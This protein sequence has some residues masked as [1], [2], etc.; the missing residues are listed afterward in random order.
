MVPWDESRQ[1]I[2]EFWRLGYTK[3]EAAD[4][5]DEN[6]IPPLGRSAALVAE[7]F[8]TGHTGATPSPR[9]SRV[10][11]D[12]AWR[13][14]SASHT[15]NNGLRLMMVWFD[16]LLI[17][18]QSLLDGKLVSL[19]A[20][21]I[22]TPLLQ[23]TREVPSAPYEKRR[24]T[25]RCLVSEVPGYVRT[26]RYCPL[27]ATI[28]TDTFPCRAWWPSSIRS[29]SATATWLCPLCGN[30][31]RRSLSIDAVRTRMRQSR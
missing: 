24:E 27:S 8:E 5:P 29:T 21:I 18:D 23:L 10:S 15:R 22:R 2:S 20:R 28:H 19:L 9:S 3:L 6:A 31:L 12:D 11:Q 26:R 13:K 7:S 4:E 16:C 30:G 14:P 1:K 17:G 25:L